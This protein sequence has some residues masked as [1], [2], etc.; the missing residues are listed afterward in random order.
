LAEYLEQKAIAG[1]RVPFVIVSIYKGWSPWKRN[2]S[3]NH[4][5]RIWMVLV[6]ETPD[7][8]AQSA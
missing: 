6:C 7:R 5:G 8:Y 3:L 2:R 4:I 1:E